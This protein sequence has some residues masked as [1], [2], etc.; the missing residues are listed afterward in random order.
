MICIVFALSKSTIV[1]HVNCIELFLGSVY[2]FGDSR[3][4]YTYDVKGRAFCLHWKHTQ[5]TYSILQYKVST[6]A[7][8]E[9]QNWPNR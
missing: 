3:K 8:P 4:F 2:F 9:I 1:F 6:M 5:T 7:Q